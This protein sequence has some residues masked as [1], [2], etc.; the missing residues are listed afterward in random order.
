MDA[1]NGLTIVAIIV[2]LCMLFG[3]Q[4]KLIKTKEKMKIQNDD[5]NAR[6]LMANQLYDDVYQQNVQMRH[7]KHDI[8][9]LMANHPEYD[10][11]GTVEEL[12]RAIFMGKEKRAEKVGV[13][14][15]VDMVSESEKQPEDEKGL[16]KL[17][18]KVFQSWDRE[19]VVRLI[20][21]ILNNAIEAAEKCEE[22]KVDIL[23]KKAEE[24]FCITVRNT[25]REGVSPINNEF[26]TDKADATE[27]GYGSKIIR[28]IVDKHH[29][30]LEIEEGENEFILKVYV[31]D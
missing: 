19:D 18:E 23:L 15:S 9:E 1:M 21:N 25:M 24:T 17:I 11:C 30:I 16:S 8:R 6:I 12:L 4:I 10:S 3:V 7:L 26:K 29:A 31:Y 20:A 22:G 27:H 2:L 28:E 13:K 14:F 5:N